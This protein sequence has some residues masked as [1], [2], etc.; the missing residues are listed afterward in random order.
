MKIFGFLNNDPRRV[1][2]LFFIIFTIAIG[3]DLGIVYDGNPEVLKYLQFIELTI[4]A[5]GIIGFYQILSLKNENRKNTSLISHIENE[6][7]LL[8]ESHITS[9]DHFFQLIERSFNQWAFSESEKIIAYFLLRGKSIKEIAE[10]RS[11]SE[12]TIRNQCHFIYSKSG[13]AGKHDLS[14]FFLQKLLQ[15]RA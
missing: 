8:Q 2:L 7:R 12:S 13:L 3:L 10:A 9:T 6:K 4:F 11:V 1:G 15:D 14:S 5:L